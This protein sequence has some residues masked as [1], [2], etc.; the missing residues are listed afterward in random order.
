[1]KY[2]L[3]FLCFIVSL[4]SAEISCSLGQ[5]FGHSLQRIENNDDTTLRQVPLPGRGA[6]FVE[7]D[8]YDKP[9]W[10]KNDQII[11]GLAAFAENSYQDYTANYNWMTN[12]PFYINYYLKFKKIAF[13]FGLNFNVL[14][15][16]HKNSTATLAQQLGHNLLFRYNINS[17]LFFEGGLMQ[18][19]AAGSWQEETISYYAGTNYIFR[20]G[21]Y[22]ERNRLN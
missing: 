18:T 10:L 15:L 19:L 14:T 17:S 12:L 4:L 11:I 16:R 1:M 8:S 22:F 3:L 5:T 2:S 9:L 7:L 13:G 20:L 6:V 21:Y